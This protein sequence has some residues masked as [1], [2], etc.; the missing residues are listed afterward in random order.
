[1]GPTRR[2]GRGEAEAEAVRIARE[3]VAANGGAGWACGGAKPDDLA[4][5]YKRRKNVIKWSVLFDCTID[6]AIVDGPVIVLVDIETGD[7]A[8]F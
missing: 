7:A 5:G 2:F 6:G 4:P 1:L 3:F 8:Y